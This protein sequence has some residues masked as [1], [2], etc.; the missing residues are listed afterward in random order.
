MNFIVL[1]F[2]EN[3]RIFVCNYS[4]LF[5]FAW[6]K[7][8]DVCA[9][10]FSQCT[11]MHVYVYV[12]LCA[13]AHAHVHAHVHVHVH[14]HIYKH[15]HTILY[16]YTYTT[17]RGDG[18]NVLRD[19]CLFAHLALTHSIAAAHPSR[20]AASTQQLAPRKAARAAAKAARAAAQIW[21][22]KWPP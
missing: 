16:T 2:F 10:R 15:I 19:D 3:S 20:A 22:S 18:G 6:G 14:I 1:L 8:N 4:C 17:G 12:Y 21:G 13:H 7:H 9:Q 11:A 5:I